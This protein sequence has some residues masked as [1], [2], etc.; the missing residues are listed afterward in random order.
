MIGEMHPRMPFGAPAESELPRS[1]VARVEAPVT[2][3]TAM[4]TACG[5]E[6]SAR[7][8]ACA[9]VLRELTEITVHV[10]RIA[11]W[12]GEER[13]ACGKQGATTARSNDCKEQRLQGA[14]TGGS[15]EQIERLHRRVASK[16]FELSLR[17][18]LVA[19]EMS[20]K[21]ERIA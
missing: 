11:Q 18:L 13:R 1:L 16:G 9:S 5:R 17:G 20:M 7:I 10:H 2:C 8:C 4:T 3:S 12:S 6:S 21:S 15:E 14:A 19:N